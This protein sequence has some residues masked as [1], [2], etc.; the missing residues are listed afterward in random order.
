MRSVE[1][2]P[3]NTENLPNIKCPKCDYVWDMATNVV[4][5]GKVREG[6]VSICLG[7]VSV[8]VFVNNGSVREP[9]AEE[10]KMYLADPTLQK[11]LEFIKRRKNV[12]GQ[13]NKDLDKH[14]SE[15]LTTWLKDQAET[16]SIAEIPISIAA[17]DAINTM[18]KAAAGVAM[19]HG[20]WDPD[21]FASHAKQVFL[22]SKA[23]IES[24][25]K[26][27][28]EGFE[29]VGPGEVKVKSL[30]QATPTSTAEMQDVKFPFTIDKGDY[31]ATAPGVGFMAHEAATI[32]SPDDLIAYLKKC[33][34][35]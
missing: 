7:C 13:T 31:I 21:K 10:A 14:F 1:F 30:S 20:E 17:R 27:E 26:A 4:G 23:I 35:L 19:G 33:G 9:T 29:Q 18:L 12:D 22:H 11:T 8:M 32:T 34:Q 15:K 5:E 6:D 2:L 24:K 16:Y 25:I 3:S 28:K